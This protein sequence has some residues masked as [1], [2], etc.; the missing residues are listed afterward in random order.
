M[1]RNERLKGFPSRGANLRVPDRSTQPH[2][3]PVGDIVANVTWLT[4]NNPDF[5]ERQATDV[6]EDIGRRAGFDPDTAARVVRL[7]RGNSILIIPEENKKNGTLTGV[8]AIAYAAFCKSLAANTATLGESRP[9][10]IGRPLNSAIWKNIIDDAQVALGVKGTELLRY[11][12]FLRRGNRGQVGNGEV[13][14]NGKEAANVNP[15]KEKYYATIK[16]KMPQLTDEQKIELKA[17]NKEKIKEAIAL[18]SPQ[19][20]I[21]SSESEEDVEMA[22]S[23]VSP[24]PEDE[25]HDPIGDNG[26]DGEVMGTQVVPRHVAYV[27]YFIMT[28]KNHHLIGVSRMKVNQTTFTPTNKVL[29]EA[30]GC[31]G[32][33]LDE[34][35]KAD[36]RKYWKHGNKK[37]APASEEYEKYN[38]LELSELIQKKVEENMAAGVV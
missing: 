9:Y 8:H 30:L 36:E 35:Q 31:V 34:W 26:G 32:Y 27:A 6:Y 16:E 19:P 5:L 10:E 13:G 37:I 3:L 23:E 7:A 28:L 38:L 1:V 17:W 22:E 25:Q 11:P 21:E 15:E 24:D 33:L 14:E 12:F 4:Q 18:L 2:G 29:V 20:K